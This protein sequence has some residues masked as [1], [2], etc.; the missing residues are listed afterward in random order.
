MSLNL[1]IKFVFFR[2]LKSSSFFFSSSAG[3]N[4]TGRIC[5]YHQGAGHKKIYNKIDFFRR[6]NQYGTVLKIIKDNYRT[7][8][9]AFVFYDNGLCSFIVLA[10]GLKVGDRLFSGIFFQQ[11]NS[12]GSTF[13]LKDIGLFS[14]V[15]CFEVFPL[16]GA[17]FCRAAGVSALLISKDSNK[18]L[19]KLPSG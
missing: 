1:Y 18:V 3:R 19:L 2:V 4:F 6:L 11:K 15:N 9:V 13:L 7:A 17:Q 10:D 8:F 12:N 16:S 5:V 14:N